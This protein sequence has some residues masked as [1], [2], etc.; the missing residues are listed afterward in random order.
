[1]PPGPTRRAVA[2]LWE[3]L[4]SGVNNRD[5]RTYET[6]LET[7]LDLLARIPGDRLVVTESGILAPS[8]VARMRARAVQAFLVGEAFMRATDPGIALEELFATS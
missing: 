8:D 2:T 4:T 1:M 5:L 6:R 7:T 3:V